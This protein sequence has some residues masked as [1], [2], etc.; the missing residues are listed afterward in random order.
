MNELPNY[1]G[2]SL[3]LLTLFLLAVIYQFAGVRW[4][5]QP[6]IPLA[7]GVL[8]LLSAYAVTL[9]ISGNMRANI[10]VGEE[11]AK[12]GKIQDQQAIKTMV[13]M[14]EYQ[15]KLLEL[16]TIPLAVSMIAAAL[17]AR[18]DRVYQAR[19]VEYEERRATLHERQQKLAEDDELLDEELKNGARGQGVIDRYRALSKRYLNSID[20]HFDVLDDFSDLIRPRLVHGVMR[21]G[22]QFPPRA[23][24]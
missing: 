6:W 7:I 8:L 24:R 16:V 10:A 14:D 15:L 3:L 20:E 1:M 5:T 12:K 18:V 9:V 2:A 13:T 21:A 17:F 23:R 22:R 19:V 11:M 4:K